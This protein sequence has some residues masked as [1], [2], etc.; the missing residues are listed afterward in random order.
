M[1]IEQVVNQAPNGLHDAYL[2]KLDVDY[3]ERVLRFNLNLWVGNLDSSV[4]QEREAF[5]EGNLIVRGLEYLVI[6]SPTNSDGYRA[7]Q[8]PSHIDGFITRQPDIE[9]VSLPPVP[10][11]ASRYSIFVGEWN[12]FMHFAG[13]SAELDPGVSTITPES[14]A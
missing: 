8:G 4:E 5:R 12:S 2:L 7:Y 3:R 1:T 10:E 9:R 13:S 11:N 6:E 14:R